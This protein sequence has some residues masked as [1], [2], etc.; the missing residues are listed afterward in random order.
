MAVTPSG[1]I[2]NIFT[3]TVNLGINP[4]FKV[5]LWLLTIS[6]GFTL[7]MNLLSLIGILFGVFVY[8]QI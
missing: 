7:K 5:D 8:K 2:Q 6:V 4:P 1:V 3:K